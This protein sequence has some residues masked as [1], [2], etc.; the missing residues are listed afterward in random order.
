MLAIGRAWR[1]YESD[2]GGAMRVITETAVSALDVERASVWL[3]T[4]DRHELVC[5]DLFER[6]PATHS[7][8]VRLRADDYPSY[9]AALEL[10]EVIAAEDAHHDPRTSEFSQSYLAPLGIGAMLDAPIR[11][12]GHVVGVLCHEHVG[13]AREF[14][15]DEQNTANYLAS[16]A[17]LALELRKRLESETELAESLSLLRAAFEATGEGILAV[18][19]QGAVVEF[20]QRFIDMWDVPGELLGPAG[21]G[22]PRLAH[23]ASKTI[24]PEGYV[25]R[26]R[27]VFADTEAEAVDLFTLVDGRS[28]ERTSRPQWLG[29]KAI[30][31]VW[32]FRDVTQQKRIEAA[33]RASEARQSELASR[34]PL[35][36]LY[37]RRHVHQHLAEEIVRARRT[38]R[39]F[40]IAMIDL[41][42]FKDINDAH[43]HQVGDLVLRAFAE[44]LVLRIRRTDLAGRWGGEE[45]LLVL[46]ETPKD[47]AMN[48]LE[49]LRQQVGRE[50]P[51]LP[52]FTVSIGVAE[53]PSDGTDILPLVA[54]ADERLYAAKRAGRNCIR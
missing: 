26:A 10:E 9:F 35:T 48:L 23:L 29:G 40:T 49:E 44:D 30:G 47:S 46:P 36:D 53:F 1:H 17:S 51:T 38:G 2:V 15:L 28:I 31:R 42:H 12:G 20:N 24:D 41:D 52:R 25:A 8:G 54:V 32:S 50:R 21:D 27:Q 6:T 11:S 33:L 45:F 39:A 22:G 37:N 16:L 5:D 19:H 3:L 7:N 14:F 4:N 18:D 43:G 34:D 13:P